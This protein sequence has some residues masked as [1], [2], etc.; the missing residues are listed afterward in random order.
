M[1]HDL[2]PFYVEL[3]VYDSLIRDVVNDKSEGNEVGDY[4]NETTADKI[5]ESTLA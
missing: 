4:K 1:D 2:L 5:V 3:L